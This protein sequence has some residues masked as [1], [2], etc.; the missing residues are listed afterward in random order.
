MVARMEEQEWRD[1]HAEFEAQLMDK[2][3]KHLSAE[4]DPD[5][6]FILCEP[7]VLELSPR[8]ETWC[9]CYSRS[10]ARKY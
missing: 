9:D 10:I 3:L 7:G 8:S 2:G 4:R 5:L 1:E 6:Y